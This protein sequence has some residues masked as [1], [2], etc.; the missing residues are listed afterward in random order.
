M[1]KNEQNISEPVAAATQEGSLVILGDRWAVS[2][3]SE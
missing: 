1:G 2:G 3:L